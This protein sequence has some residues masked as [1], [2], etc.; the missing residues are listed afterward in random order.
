[1]NSPARENL[2]I[3]LANDPRTATPEQ[4]SAAYMQLTAMTSHRGDGA[5][6]QYVHGDE[7]VRHA[8]VMWA[9]LLAVMRE[10]TPPH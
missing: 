7:V 4:A 5:P 1:M 8:K 2:D 10:S 6:T 3:A 9:A